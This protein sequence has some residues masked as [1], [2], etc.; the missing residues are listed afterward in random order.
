MYRWLAIFDGLP[1]PLELNALHLIIVQR[2]ELL[3]EYLVYQAKLLHSMDTAG[4]S[5]LMK[6]TTTT[7]LRERPLQGLTKVLLGLKTARLASVGWAS[8][9]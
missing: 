6:S 7:L 8:G 5:D 9:A 2:W 1:G 4:W 3:E